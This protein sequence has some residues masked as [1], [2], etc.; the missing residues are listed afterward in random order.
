MLKQF[1][2]TGYTSNNLINININNN[3]TKQTKYIDDNKLK[4]DKKNTQLSNFIPSQTILVKTITMYNSDPHTNKGII[5]TKKQNST[6]PPIIYTNKLENHLFS[7]TQD[8][9]ATLKTIFKTQ[10]GWTKL[11]SK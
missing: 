9:N 7:V 1:I 11:T 8:R 2:N 5:Q 10:C 3:D 4:K 6:T